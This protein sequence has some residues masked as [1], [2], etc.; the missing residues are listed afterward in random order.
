MHI[1]LIPLTKAR[2]SRREREREK[3]ANLFA[4]LDLGLSYACPRPKIRSGHV[5]VC[6]YV[7]LCVFYL[8]ACFLS[9]QPVSLAELAT[10][11]LNCLLRSLAISLRRRKVCSIFAKVSLVVA[12]ALHCSSVAYPVAESRNASKHVRLLNIILSIYQI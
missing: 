1:N 3:D 5:C 6:E 8:E 11:Y 10:F 12:K 2:E 4:K 7:Y 9:F